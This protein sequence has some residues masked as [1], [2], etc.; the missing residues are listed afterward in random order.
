MTEIA[1]SSAPASLRAR[2]RPG[3]EET[4]AAA[5]AR[6]ASEERFRDSGRGM[7]ETARELVSRASQM[8]DTNDRKVMLHLAAEFERRAKERAKPT[9]GLI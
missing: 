6:H 1:T 2:R 8:S 4:R 3:G 9:V 7:L 5:A